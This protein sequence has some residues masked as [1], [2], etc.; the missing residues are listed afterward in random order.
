[1]SAQHPYTSAGLTPPPPTWTAT[2]T[3]PDDFQ[4]GPPQAEIDAV[5][6]LPLRVRRDL[7]ASH[8]PGWVIC[9]DGVAVPRLWAPSAD[10]VGTVIDA[11]L[12]AGV[13]HMIDLIA[14]ARGIGR[15]AALA[16]VASYLEPCES[17]RL[18]T[19]QYLAKGAS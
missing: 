1:M 5:R 2:A 11:W 15:R 8:G 18:A 12:P 7:C 19:L 17:V 14:S 13:C 10:A 4:P 6:A 9:L 3:A 16:I